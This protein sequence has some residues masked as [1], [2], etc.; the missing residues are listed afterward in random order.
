MCEKLAAAIHANKR[1]YWLQ[2]MQHMSKC[3]QAIDKLK[4]DN[5][6][7]AAGESDDLI[8]VDEGK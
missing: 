5:E 6:T 2:V 3:F 4:V 8:S 7:P 1:V